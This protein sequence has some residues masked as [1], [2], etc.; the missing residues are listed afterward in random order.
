MWLRSSPGGTASYTGVRGADTGGMPTRSSA[1]DPSMDT[2][3]GISTESST[4]TKHPR[5]IHV[6]GQRQN[7]VCFGFGLR[8]HGSSSIAALTPSPV[9]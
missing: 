7:G 5:A 2:D 4:T 9:E 3:A 8:T 6:C 1:R